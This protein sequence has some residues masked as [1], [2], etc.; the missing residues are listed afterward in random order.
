MTL[1]RDPLAPLGRIRPRLQR[2]EVLP[3][4][5]ELRLWTAALRTLGSH[6]G[7]PSFG[8]HPGQ[9]GP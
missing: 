2:I 6:R 8:Y 4:I 9:E 1:H 5:T 3:G 7:Q